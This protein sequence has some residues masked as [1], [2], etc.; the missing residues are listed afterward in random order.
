MTQTRVRRREEGGRV[1][2]GRGSKGVMEEGRRGKGKEVYK[3]TCTLMHL[4]L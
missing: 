2:G 1:G 3:C 4:D